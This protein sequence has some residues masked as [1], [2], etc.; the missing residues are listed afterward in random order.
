[1]TNNKLSSGGE[2][3]HPSGNTFWNALFGGLTGT[4]GNRWLLNFDK[5][6][7]NYGKITYEKHC[8]LLQGMGHY[9]N[10]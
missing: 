6:I 8:S 4:F 9:P 3:T 10:K 1:M 5:I 2:A 7:Y